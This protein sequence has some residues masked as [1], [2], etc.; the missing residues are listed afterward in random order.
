MPRLISI[1]T[2]M[3]ESTAHLAEAEPTKRLTTADSRTMPTTVAC[4]GSPRSRRK[5]APLSAISR[6][7]FELLKAAMNWAA[8]KAMTR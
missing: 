8:K 3:T 4:A 6:P 1:G 7:T 5:F 2:K